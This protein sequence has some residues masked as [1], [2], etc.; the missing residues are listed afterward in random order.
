MI[1]RYKAFNSTVDSALHFPELRECIKNDAPADVQITYGEIPVNGLD[2][3]LKSSPFFQANQY[4]FWMNIPKVARFLVK[5]GQHIIIDP[6]SNA[7][8]TTLRIFTLESC[9]KALLSQQNYLVLE[10][11]AIQMGAFAVLF[12]APSGFG[13]STLA[14][15]FLKRG[16]SVLTDEICAI[17]QNLCLHPSFPVINL[18]ANIAE[19]VEIDSTSLKTMRST[20]KKYRLDLHR[21]AEL[22]PLPI[23]LIY[24]LNYHKNDSLVLSDISANP[25]L[26]PLINGSITPPGLFQSTKALADS[27]PTVNLT[28]PRWDYGMNQLGYLLTPLL[29]TIERDVKT[30]ILA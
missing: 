19:Q 13:K 8:E 15:M 2:F 14:S 6:C 25:R 24:T 22:A 17:D 27:V 11:S 18:W 3:S 29:D 28:L 21:E 10:G 7:E 30:R 20:V 12:L 23:K 4:S 5:D 16:Y 1:H 26:N 9:F